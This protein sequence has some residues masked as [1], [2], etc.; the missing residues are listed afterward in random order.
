MAYNGETFI[1]NSYPARLYGNTVR[2]L[3]FDILV[4]MIL[5]DTKEQLST[6]QEQI[7]I[8]SILGDGCIEKNGNHYRV[9]FGHS[10]AQK[11]YLIWKQNRLK[12]FCTSKI[13]CFDVLDSRTEKYYS[14]VRFNTKSIKV[15]DKYYQMF[16]LNKRKSVPENISDLLKS[17]IALAVWYLDDGAKRTDCNAL[18][19]HTNCYRKGEQE[20]LINMLQKNFGI[21]AKLHKVHNEEYVIYIPSEE[22]KRFCEIIEPIVDE[23]PSMRYKLL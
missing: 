4:S 14:H 8:G 6:E 3:E 23:I 19:I 18:R 20:V 1:G 22:S 12:D 2:S 13:T 7:L 15:F 11:E 21:I 16:Y 5:V 17:P 9:K 10:L